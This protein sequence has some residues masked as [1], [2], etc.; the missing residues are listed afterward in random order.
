MSV[1]KYVRIYSAQ[2]NRET[3]GQNPYISMSVRADDPEGEQKIKDAKAKQAIENREWKEKIM[4]EGGPPRI[5]RRRFSAKNPLKDN[6]V[7]D[8]IT[9]PEI[10]ITAPPEEKKISEPIPIPKAGDR[11]HP[12]WISHP[13]E[14][15]PIKREP[16]HLHLQGH[17]GNTTYVLGSSKR[18]KST[19]MMHIYDNYY[20]GSDK[21]FISMLWAQNPQIGLYKNHS[22]LIVGNWHAKGGEDIIKKQHTIQRKTG[23]EYKFLNIF[24]D[25]LDTRNSKLI[26]SLIMTYRNSKMSTIIAMQYC[27]LLSK[28]NRT[29]VNNVLLFGFNAD[30]AIE[31]V[32][33]CYL[34]GYLK[35]IGIIKMPDMIN[36]YKSATDD[37][38]FIY[39]QPEAD[40]YSFHRI[41]V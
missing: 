27:N 33:K 7:D 26:N 18:G 12:K 1:R 25:I 23:N 30:E 38:G 41:R 20:S 29:N 19:V 10:V 31:V 28:A 13:P 35:K 11:S 37:H 6:I 4:K 24:D 14:P 21:K 9:V 22:K 17:T 34:Q 8:E 40:L 15:V 32:I 3:G 39:I 16:F 5:Q 36:W 2:K